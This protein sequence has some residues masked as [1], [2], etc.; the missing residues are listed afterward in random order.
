MLVHT[1]DDS[2]SPLPSAPPPEDAAM[3]DI[4]GYPSQPAPGYYEEPDDVTG[5]P[6]V[7][8]TSSTAPGYYDD[9]CDVTGN[10]PVRM[11]S[12]YEDS[13]DVTGNAPVR[14][15]STSSELSGPLTP[16]SQVTCHP[17]WAPRDAHGRPL[18]PRDLIGNPPPAYEESHN[19][20]IC[21]L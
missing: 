13:G 19:D 11:T 21:P 4:L 1:P 10:A 2:A 5:S 8:M 3:A 7:R 14:M 6:P 17:S 18:A 20:R 12:Y 16:D 15:T 9:S